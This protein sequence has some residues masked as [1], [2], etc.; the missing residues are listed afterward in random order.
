MIIHAHIICWNRADTIHLTIQHYLKFCDN[1]FIYDNFSDDNTREIA[2]SLGC[3]VKLFG[4]SGILD[5]FEYKKLKNNCWRG[6][7][8][9]WVIIV[10]DDEILYNEDLKFILNQGRVNGATIF[11]PQGYSMHSDSMPKEDWL[12]IRT[13]FRD[14]NYSKLCIFNP[15]EIKEIGYEFG[16]H[17]H[18]K[19]YPQGRMVF[20]RDQLY[21]LHYRSVGGVDRLLKRWAEYEPRRQ[22]SAINM[23]WNLGKQ[24]A[25]KE[26]DIRKE[27][28]QS[29]EKSKSLSDLGIM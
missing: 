17:A 26:T 16:C 14:N 10:D 5:D 4:V 28:A 2:E 11:K 21:L 12:E 20:G 1:I 24:Y 29:L 22:K 7:T 19:G 13:G 3:E 15:S 9:D 8:A 27:W 23:R 6:S 25:Q 18:M